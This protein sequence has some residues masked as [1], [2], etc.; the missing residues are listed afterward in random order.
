MHRLFRHAVVVLLLAGTFFMAHAA[1]SADDASAIRRVMADQQAAWN[2]GDVGG[3]MRG[4]K[5]APDTTF[6]GSSVRKGYREILASYREHYATKDQ[7]GQLTF[8]DLDVR[9]L[10]GASGAVRYAV[11]TGHFHLD[12]Q[13]H[14]S[15]AQ[16]DGVYSL[17]W[18]KTP[19]GWKIILDHTS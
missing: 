14:G 18:E 5:D 19:D 12:R 10:P 3:F 4:Y 7:M 13:A 6:V 9:L 15:V 2:R 17:L 8:S 16:D 1:A 11:V